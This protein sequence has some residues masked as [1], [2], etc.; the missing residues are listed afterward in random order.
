MPKRRLDVEPDEESQRASGSKRARFDNAALQTREFEGDDARIESRAFRKGKQRASDNMGEDEDEQSESP[1][2]DEEVELEKARE[3]LRQRR[4]Q[5]GTSAKYGIIEK[6]EMHQFMCHRYLTFDL[7]SRINF[8]IGHNGSGKSAVLSAITV[9]LGGKANS[10]GRGNGLKSFIR[11]GQNAA[12]VTIHLKNQGEEAYKHD[13]YGDSIIVT[14]KFTRDGSSSYAIKSKSGKKVSGKREELSAI[15]DHMSIQVDNPM[16]ILTQDASRQFLNSAKA[17]DKYKF[18]LQGT[19]LAQLSEEYELCDDNV[20]RMLDILDT[21]RG[22]ISDLKSAHSDAKSRLREAEAAR[23]RRNKSNDLKQELAWAHVLVKADELRARV[24]ATAK[25]TH[26]VEKLRGKLDTAQQAV[27]AAKASF[28]EKERAHEELGNVEDLDA[29]VA[30]LKASISAQKKITSELRLEETNMNNEVQ[31]IRGEIENVNREKRAE[32]AKSASRLEGTHEALVRRL[33]DAEAELGNATTARQT[34]EARIVEK[35][36]ERA[37]VETAAQQADRDR[38]EADMT[39]KG[40]RQQRETVE[41]STQDDLA[42]FGQNLHQALDNIRGTHWYGDTPVGP[43]GQYVKLRDGQ[44]AV[45]LRIQIGRLMSAFAITDMRDRTTL[46]KILKDSGNSQA[47]IIVAGLDLFDY[48]R[49][50]PDERFLTILRA[51]EISDEYVKRVLV[52]Q[53]R[54]ERT[55]LF[56]KRDEADEVLKAQ[57]GGGVGITRDGF[58]VTRFRDSGGS[59]N[60]LQD[61]GAR[62]R[63]HLM[64]T[65]RDKAAQIMDWRGREQVAEQAYGEA[66][67]RAQELHSNFRRA[68]QELKDAQAAAQRA[69]AEATKAKRMRDQLQQEV[70]DDVSLDMAG[71]DQALAELEDKLRRTADQFEPI[72]RRKA[73]IEAE[74]TKLTDQSKSVK[75]VILD[76]HDRK[77]AAREEVE[78]AV[79]ARAPLQNDLRHW[80]KSIDAERA[81]LQDSKREEDEARQHYEATLA[82]ATECCAR[83]ETL[84]VPDAIEREITATENALRERERRGGISVEDAEAEVQ[85]TQA[86]MHTVEVELAELDALAK[87]LKGCLKRRK[88]KWIAFL[89]FMSVR[90]KTIFQIRLS[91]R[92]YSGRILMDHE[93]QTLVL[94]VRTERDEA[95]QGGPTSQT[96]SH[97][98][99]TRALSGGEKSFTTICLLLSMWDA[100]S[101]PIRCLDEFDVYMDDVTRRVACKMIIDA[102]NTSNAEQ[103]VF[104]TP[105]GMDNI[106][107]GNTV[108]VHRMRDPERS[109][110]TLAFG[111][112][113]AA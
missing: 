12:E 31:Y 78:N 48:S 74:I 27:D 56:H 106:H 99:D 107:I 91:N 104:I 44:W 2:T 21:K 13:L 16:N 47:P 108:R 1:D 19:L 80:Q 92:G 50:E 10:T 64:F 87:L 33:E 98:R 40:A 100:I 103:Y 113:V 43:F 24:D 59:S 39:R 7:G 35:R 75:R 23:D 54:I 84:R 6:V 76:F 28:Q 11:E 90:C 97:M 86:A 65:N 66:L 72:A 22:A 26:R 49:G 5:P 53:A 60:P 34:A 79:A 15:C 102:A 105:K 110:G 109:Q 3:S 8:V 83:V 88:K 81:K 32:M 101:S 14:R 85:R 4:N 77:T 29:Q 71:F 25:I 89:G 68:D 112:S 63:R 95:T 18:F 30:T 82:K 67:A 20:R 58:I 73:E 94:K 69:G 62:D 36:A 45:P 42:A 70:N 52:N 41:S 61:L 37:S 96:G 17:S 9:G 111:N 57:N 51:V 93:N 38:A 46:A 55:M